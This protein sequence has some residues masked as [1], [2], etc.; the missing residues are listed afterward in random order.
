MLRDKYKIAYPNDVVLEETSEWKEAQN[1][2]PN[3]LF[4]SNKFFYC[5]KMEESLFVRVLWL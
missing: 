2:I 5:S 3:L 1:H 4:L